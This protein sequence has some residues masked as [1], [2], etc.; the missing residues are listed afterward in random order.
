[1]ISTME[2]IGK[3]GSYR[4]MLRYAPRVLREATPTC[5]HCVNDKD[6]VR[7]NKIH[8]LINRM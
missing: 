4:A 5:D 2:L 6:D 7:V 3:A 8:R 1:M